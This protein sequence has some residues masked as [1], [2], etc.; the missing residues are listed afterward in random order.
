MEGSIFNSGSMMFGW[1]IVSIPESGDDKALR[2]YF[3]VDRGDKGF[4]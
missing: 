2:V 3:I 4:W 1:M